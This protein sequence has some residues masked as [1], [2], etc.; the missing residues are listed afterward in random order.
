MKKCAVLLLCLIIFAKGF[1]KGVPEENKSISGSERIS[2]EYEVVDIKKQNKQLFSVVQNSVL[3][4]LEIL[5]TRIATLNSSG[6]EKVMN[7]STGE[8][9]QHVLLRREA[10]P[11]VFI[12]NEASPVAEFKAKEAFE[13][14]GE[15]ATAFAE[16]NAKEALGFLENDAPK[17][18]LTQEEIQKKEEQKKQ[19]DENFT[20][21]SSYIESILA[22]LSMKPDKEFQILF[23]NNAELMIYYDLTK[24]H[25]INTN[26]YKKDEVQQFLEERFGELRFDL[27]KPKNIIL[28][29]YIVAYIMYG[30]EKITVGNI[31]HIFDLCCSR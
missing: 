29:I 1:A 12:R 18:E 13:F 30:N 19:K 15:D 11:F 5:D 10:E 16:F 24:T 8:G 7:F 22:S 2:W 27:D 28:D 20:I 26:Q 3:D 9:H 14:E 23:G 31:A 25:L 21:N 4:E 17:K 6:W